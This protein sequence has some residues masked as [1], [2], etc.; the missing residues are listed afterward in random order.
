[1]VV[2]PF[3]PEEQVLPDRELLD[4]ILSMLEDDVASTL[5]AAYA[6]FEDRHLD[7]E[8]VLMGTF[9]TVAGGADGLPELSRDRRLLIGAYYTR[10]F[11]IEAAALTNPSIVPAP[12]QSGLESGAQRFV[13]SLRGIGEGHVSS[14]E[15]R[16]GVINASGGIV[17]EEPSGY[18]GTG[19]RSPPLYDK[20]MFRARLNEMDASDEMAGLVIDPLPDRFDLHQLEAAIA[21]VEDERGLRRLSNPTCRTI[22]W[23]A[24]SNY[25]LVFAPESSLSERVIF[26][27]SAI[28][29]HGLED[30]RF[31]RF[32]DDDGSVTY[33][34]TYTAYD[35]F[36]VLPQLIETKDFASFRIAT[37]SGMCAQNKGAAL[38]P[39]KIDGRYAALS[40]Y[41]GENNYVM[42][43]DS[44][45]IWETADR[46]ESPQFPWQLAR[47]GNCGSPLETEAGWLVITHGVGPFRSYSL[48]AILLDIDDPCR[49]IGQLDQP[50]LAWLEDEREGYV[51]NIVY[52]CGAMIHGD[53]LILPYGFSDMA[54]R[55]AKVPLDALL[56]TLV[57]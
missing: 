27:G 30:A 25:V 49:V 35:G 10:E 6:H 22:H 57:G 17:F 13:M 32:T 8:S 37:L 24:T 44:V 42:R 29:S 5:A 20:S 55:I 56:A 3:L 45:R 40:R 51:P 11:S 15:F 1:V 7:L 21:T 31:V 2:R 28:E 18:A 54:T 16:S 41:D 53:E 52:S 48:G 38:F 19:T 36:R 14:I 34:A 50:L 4:R 46:I 39:R 26:A 33:Y 47:I 9:E 12:D 43:S 23:L